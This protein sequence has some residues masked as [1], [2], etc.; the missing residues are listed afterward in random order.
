MYRPNCSNIF[1][2]LGF[3]ALR[4]CPLFLPLLFVWLMLLLLLLL[5]LLLPCSPAAALTSLL[6]VVLACSGVAAA[7]AAA[8]AVEVPAS[9]A[10]DACTATSSCASEGVDCSAC[11]GLVKQFS[12]TA[13]AAC[14]PPRG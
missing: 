8:S 12:T 11:A 2:S 9:A 1:S 4:E 6:L 13:E 10:T 14:R 7:A 5:L 3:F